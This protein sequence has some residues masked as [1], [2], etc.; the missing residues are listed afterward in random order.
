MKRIT[1]TIFSLFL[2]SS[3]LLNAQEIPRMKIADLQKIIAESKQPMVISFWSTYCQPCL[4][5]IPYFHDE[6]VARAGDSVRLLLVSLDLKDFYP[7]RIRATAIRNNLK[8]D[9][10]WLDEYNADYFC[11][12]V[13]QKWSGAI[14]ATLFI[15]NAKNYHSFFEAQIPREKFKKE[16]AAMLGQSN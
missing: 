2:L 6:V 10:A 1:V 13:D 7:D 16:L 14:P 12:K 3:A 11:P 5:E 8:D 9:I 15:N 4:E